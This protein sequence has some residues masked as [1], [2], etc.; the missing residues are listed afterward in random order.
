MAD[1]NGTLDAIGKEL[2]ANPPAVL[3]ATR[4]KF[5]VERAEKQRT[6]ILLSKGRQAGLKIP[7]PI[8]SGG[9]KSTSSGGY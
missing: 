9:S 5:G 7:K 8:S 4:R 6:A 1:K 3:N 2:K